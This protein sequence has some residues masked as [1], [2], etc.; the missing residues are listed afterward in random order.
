M[1]FLDTILFLRVKDILKAHQTMVLS[2]IFDLS[3]GDL[4]MK[5][6]LFLWFWTDA[7]E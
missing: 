1:V 5:N 7:G 2:L 6:D 4:A 3:V